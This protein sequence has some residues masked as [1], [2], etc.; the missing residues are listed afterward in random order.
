MEPYNL[1]LPGE[2]GFWEYH[3]SIKFWGTKAQALESGYLTCK[4]LDLSS[5]LDTYNQ[6]RFTQKATDKDA[7]RL[8]VAS[9]HYLCPQHKPKVQQFIQEGRVP[10]TVE[11][12]R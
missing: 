8:V 5:P 3:R 9:S 4:F 2:E 1:S 6:L 7:Q 11:F 12:P 10:W